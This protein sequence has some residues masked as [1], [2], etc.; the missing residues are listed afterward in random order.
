M[1][2][3]RCKHCSHPV[4]FHADQRVF[5]HACMEEITGGRTQI[6]SCPGLEVEP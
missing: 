2:E 3:V 6:C 5:G 1:A 4:S